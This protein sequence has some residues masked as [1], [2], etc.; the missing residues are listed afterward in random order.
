MWV[1]RFEI[2]ASFLA[3]VIYQGIVY[4]VI[5]NWNLQDSEYFL[6]WDNRNTISGGKNDIGPFSNFIGQYLTL[7]FS[8][9]D[10]VLFL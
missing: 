6:I 3:G 2:V 1:V 8:L 5:C 7:C 4:M 9:L 10:A